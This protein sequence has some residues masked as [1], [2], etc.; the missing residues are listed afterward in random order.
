MSVGSSNGILLLLFVDKTEF[1]YSFVFNRKL[2]LFI[3]PL[4]L[5]LVPMEVENQMLSMPCSLF[6]VREHL[7]FD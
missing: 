2:D 3:N 1:V 5:L 7:N 4:P 6:S